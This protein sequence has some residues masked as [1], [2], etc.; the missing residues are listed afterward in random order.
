MMIKSF[1]ASL[2]AL[3]TMA[4][5]VEIDIPNFNEAVANFDEK[6]PIFNQ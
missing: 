4:V 1:I 5:S 2:F 3:A 6:A